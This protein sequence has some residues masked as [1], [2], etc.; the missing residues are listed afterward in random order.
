MKRVHK[1]AINQPAMLDCKSVILNNGLAKDI[2]HSDLLALHFGLE[3]VFGTQD[4][5]KV[6]ENKNKGIEIRK[7]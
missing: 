7:K 3:V 5:T 6:D 4:K 2:P 1:H